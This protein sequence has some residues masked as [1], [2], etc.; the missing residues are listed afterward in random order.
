MHNAV[1]L[2]SRPLLKCHAVTLPK[3][4]RASLAGCKSILQLA[5]FRNGARVPGLQTAKQKF[6]WLP[7][8][9]VAAVT[10]PRSETR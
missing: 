5:T 2:G 9:D 7:L 6:G 1:K 3:Y 10:L 8:S 4:K